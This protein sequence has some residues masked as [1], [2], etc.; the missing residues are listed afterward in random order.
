VSCVLRF[1]YYISS[2]LTSLLIF[3]QGVNVSANLALNIYGMDPVNI[4]ID[5]CNLFNGGLCPLPM[6]NF[7]GADTLTLPPSLAIPNIPAIVYKIPDLE[8][9]FQLIL[10]EVDTGVVTA[11]IQA[12]ISN[13]RSAHQHAVEWATG[14]IALAALLSAG[15]YSF[16]YPEATVPFRF[17]ELIYL[18]QSIASS[19]F[20]SL[21]YPSFYR[22]FSLNFAWSVGL[23]PS[24]TIQNSINRMRH[25]TGGHLADATDGSAV[26]FVNRKLSPYDDPDVLTKLS[27][28]ELA[29]PFAKL[30]SSLDIVTVPPLRDATTGGVQVVTTESSNV[31]QA[32][33]PI[34]VNTIHIATANA[35]MTVFIFV[36]CMFAIA[37]IIFIMG[38]GSIFALDH[39]RERRNNREGSVSHPFS[40]KSFSFVRGWFLRLVCISSVFT[41]VIPT[42]NL[43]RF[44]SFW[45]LSLSS[46][47][48]STNGHSRIHGFLFFSLFLPSLQ[49]QASLHIQ[50]SRFF[51]SYVENHHHL[52]STH[53]MDCTSHGMGRFTPNIVP[54][55]TFS[56]LF[57][58]LASSFGLF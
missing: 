51:E 32:G 6:Y 24:S 43:Q 3:Q 46:F 11:C 17:L 48:F 39:I 42:A 52:L 10:T 13:G 30:S 15:W 23:I 38:Y 7:T 2:N 28:R 19:S 53:T 18:Y 54:L 41:I 50:H 21:N 5:L 44:R 55:D 31:L 49:L 57:S 37:A 20:L 26:G 25:L 58:W 27:S 40:C 34:F 33:V 12:T 22:A 14:S 36:L 4:T 56:S 29:S 47:P 45:Q 35:F 8:G 16:A 1:P 9:F